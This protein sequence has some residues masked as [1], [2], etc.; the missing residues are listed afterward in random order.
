MNCKFL[1]I[2]LLGNKIS[3]YFLS[4]LYFLFLPN[5]KMSFWN[6]ISI[7]ARGCT[8]VNPVPYIP[9]QLLWLLNCLLRDKLIVLHSRILFQTLLTLHKIKHPIGVSI[10]SIINNI[11][12]SFEVIPKIISLFPRRARVLSLKRQYLFS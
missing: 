2:I 5:A 1:S 4:K 3:F 6:E 11:S 12:F 7:H 9:R 8:G 10:K